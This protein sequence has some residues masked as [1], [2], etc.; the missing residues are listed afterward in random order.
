[1]QEEVGAGKPPRYDP[2][3]GNPAQKGIP[4]GGS[5]VGR[6][7][8]QPRTPAS[9]MTRRRMCRASGV[10]MGGRG[11]GELSKVFGHFQMTYVRI[12]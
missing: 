8:R 12:R 1:M 11:E 7:A 2:A 4:E 6:A 5:W 10:K 3:R 9:S